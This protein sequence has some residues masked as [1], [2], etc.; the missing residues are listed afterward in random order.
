MLPKGFVVIGALLGSAGAVA[1]VRDTFRGRVK[2]NRV[3]YLLWSVA[4]MIAFAA[5]VKQGVGLESL[6]TFSAGFFPLL[7][8]LAS[9]ANANA[10]WR[11]RR[12]DLACGCLSAAGLVLWLVTK[13]GNVAI[14]FSIASDA[15]AALPTL[16]KAYEHPETEIAWPWLATCVGVSLTLLT[17]EELTLAN[18]AFILYLLVVDLAIFC[19][20]R[21]PSL[22]LARPPLARRGRRRSENARKGRNIL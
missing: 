18:S 7:T 4:P 3:S 5:Q 16:V 21:W 6:M 22:R 10:R 11:L 14:L 8:L 2:P 9:F 17:L 12:F 15:L 19:L 13:V 20:V 1:Y